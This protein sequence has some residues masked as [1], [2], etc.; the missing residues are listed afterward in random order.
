MRAVDTALL[1]RLKAVPGLHVHDGFVKVDNDSNVVTYPVPFVVFYSNVGDDHSPRLSGRNTRR[2][3]FFSLTY[4]GLTR[5]QSKWAG[6]RARAALMDRRLTVPN[7]GV[8]LVDLQESQRVRR[9]DDALR[10]D[11]S[12]LFYGIDNYAISVTRTPATSGGTL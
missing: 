2:S 4:V 3:V 6:E 12:P 1:A 7:H 5:E 9:D 11:G 8:W 10:P